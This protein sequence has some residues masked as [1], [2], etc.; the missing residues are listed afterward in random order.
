MARLR[1][2]DDPGEAW[3]CSIRRSDRSRLVLAPEPTP[4]EEVSRTCIW[5][6]ADWLQPV[7]PRS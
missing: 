4:D 2:G 6:F 3:V 1:F 5:S 7:P